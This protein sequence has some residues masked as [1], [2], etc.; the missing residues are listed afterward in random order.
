[1]ARLGAEYARSTP[2][3][4]GV[5]GRPLACESRLG[6]LGTHT[7]AVCCEYIESPQVLLLAAETRLC[8]GQGKIHGRLCSVLASSQH[9]DS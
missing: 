2:A 7:V 6:E 4:G 8:L 5:S 1:M 9:R 3:A